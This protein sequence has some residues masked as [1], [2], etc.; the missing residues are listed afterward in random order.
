[1]TELHTTFNLLKLAGAC[2]QKVGSGGRCWM[3]KVWNGARKQWHSW[4]G[5][6]ISLKRVVYSAYDKIWIVC[7]C[8]IMVVPF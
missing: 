2:G 3:P 8:G 4:F 7:G 1:M 6:P 5:H